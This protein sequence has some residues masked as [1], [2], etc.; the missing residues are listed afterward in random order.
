MSQVSLEIATRLE[1][2]GFPR[3]ESADYVFQPTIADILRELPDFSLKAVPNAA[4]FFCYRLDPA[5]YK[6]SSNAA[7][8][9]ALA[10]LAENEKK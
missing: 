6:W 9:C 5:T 7:D 3:P 8:A 4:G 10:W 2:A 1:D